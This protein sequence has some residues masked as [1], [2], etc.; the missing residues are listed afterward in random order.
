MQIL[1]FFNISP[2]TCTVLKKTPKFINKNTKEH[3]EPI[4][5]LINIKFE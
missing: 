5:N 4:H 2:Y 3:K 1:Y